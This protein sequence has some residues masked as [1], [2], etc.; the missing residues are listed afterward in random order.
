[1][2][3]KGQMA[4]SRIKLPRSALY[5]EATRIVS[6]LQAA[7]YEAVLVGGCVRDLLMHKT[8]KDYDIATNATPKVV[9]KLFDRTVPVG[10]QFGVIL[11]LKGKQTY[12]VATFRT[13][14]E[15]KDGR[16]PSRVAFCTAKEDAQRRD[17]TINGLF[18]DPHKKKLLDWVKG[19]ADLKAKKIR[20]IGDPNKRFAEDKLRMLRAVR[21]ASTLG[22]KIE[23]R[24]WAAIRRHAD[25]IRR[26]SHERIREELI[27]LFTGPNPGHGL[28]LLDESHLLNVLL[29][30]VAAM[31][32]VKQPP[33]FHPEGDVYVHTR[34]MLDLL[35]KPSPTLALAT[36]LHDI[37]KPPTFRMRERIRFDGHDQVGA[38]MA[39][40]VCKRLRLSNEET[41][42]IILSITN[43]IRFKDVQKMRVSTLKRMIRHPNFEEELELHR[44]DCAG[45]HGQ[46]GNW[47]FLKKK[48]K[49]FSKPE[50]LKPKP[51]LDGADLLKLGYAE[52]PLI[53][54]IL[55]VIEEQQLE[56]VL[57]GR[58]EAIRVVKKE[59]PKKR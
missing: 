56:G 1:M 26:V 55:G 10:A 58:E 3:G 29:P 37:G 53:G 59:F 57:K 17:F 9:Q 49:E 21:F 34:I 52:S 4:G 45:S 12:E 47:R 42:R 44:V 2:D 23:P 48:L 32:G 38:I 20:A 31:K 13:E 25:E 5:K 54:K 16:H 7:G 11:V 39:Q 40:K 33:E 43:H 18:W 51:L 46:L 14:G 22:F 36:L 6:A 35:K 24:T 19:K 28:D 27:K 15:Y 30:E 8:P 41:E 50:V